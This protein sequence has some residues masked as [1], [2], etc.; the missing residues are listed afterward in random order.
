MHRGTLTSHPSLRIKFVP[1]RCA[2]YTRYNLLQHISADTRSHFQGAHT[3]VW[4]YI[5][6][7]ICWSDLRMVQNIQE[8]GINII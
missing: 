2:L 1:I 7:E 8:L 6:A 4:L 3:K 5:L